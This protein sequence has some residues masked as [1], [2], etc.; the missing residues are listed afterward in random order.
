M[1]RDLDVTASGSATL[2]NKLPCSP[3]KTRRSQRAY[4][5]SSAQF[6]SLCVSLCLCLS[7][8]ICLSVSVSVCIRI[9]ADLGGGGKQQ[10]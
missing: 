9:Y 2:E 6:C 1:A 4:M 5:Q 10:G 7:V 8:S 3:V